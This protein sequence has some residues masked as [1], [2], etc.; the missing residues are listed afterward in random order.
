MSS[1]AVSP[2]GEPQNTTRSARPTTEA[3][4][5]RQIVQCFADKAFVARG[6]R[7]Q[8]VAQHDPVRVRLA[9]EGARVALHG[10]GI[11]ADAGDAEG[12]RIDV[13]EATVEV[14]ERLIERRDQR[15]AVARQPRQVAAAGGVD[16]DG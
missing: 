7:R 10:A 3:E 9:P 2:R 13:A 15:S 14:D 6:Q 8:A 1:T 12:F 16:D 11:V 5:F 4:P